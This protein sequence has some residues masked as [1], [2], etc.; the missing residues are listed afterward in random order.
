VAA[1]TAAEAM[2]PQT[3]ITFRFSR[4]TVGR[5]VFL[6]LAKTP[7]ADGEQVSDPGQLHI[8][9]SVRAALADSG[10][11]AEVR[12]LVAVTGDPRVKPYDIQVQV[13]GEF[14][15]KNATQEQLGL[16]CRNNAPTILFPYVRQLVESI[17]IDA[18]YGRIRLQPINIP[19]L[20]AKGEWQDEQQTPTKA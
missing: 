4:F 17:T 6:E 16:F 7:I 2:E 11:M 1:T 10:D 13:S 12:M 3:P 8:N 9:V 20:L 14:S 19:A 15:A 18:R 5:I